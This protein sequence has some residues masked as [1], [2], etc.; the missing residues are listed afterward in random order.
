MAQQFGG[1][2]SP[3]GDRPTGK[4]TPPTTNKFRGR[5]AHRANFRSKVLFLAPLPLLLSGIGE[6]RSGDA[7]GM[8]AEFGALALLLLSPWLLRDGLA[9]EEAFN[10]RKTAR[11]P[12]IPRKLFASVLTGLGVALA[13][14]GGW[15]LDLAPALV[16]GLLASGAHIASFGLDPMRNKGMQ[17]VDEFESERVAKAVDKA[18]KLVS[19]TLQA[20]GRFGDRHLEGRVETLASAAR[21]MFRAVE[22]DP[23]DL[24]SARKFMTVYLRGAR[25]ATVKFADLYSRKHEASTRADYEAL[26][27]DLEA[28]FANQRDRMLLDNRTDLDIEIEVLRDRLKQQ[29]VRAS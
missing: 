12:V 3:D 14:I 27:D 23:R 15:K 26:L 18:E 7:T 1:K 21:D 19:E 29:G 24:T 13:A 25:D 17:G 6:M 22:Q 28:S 11:K 20:A 16:F 10:S 8:I 2:F 9:A 4:P 5:K